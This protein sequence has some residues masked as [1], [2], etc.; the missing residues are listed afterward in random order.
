MRHVPK[1]QT[2]LDIALQIE[3]YHLEKLKLNHKWKITDTAASLN[4]SLAITSRYLKVA[5]WNRTHSDQLKQCDGL[6]EA[7][8]LIARLD[9]ERLLKGLQE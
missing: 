3:Q 6:N 2:F 1:K 4:R 5:S 8:E 7:L 9:R